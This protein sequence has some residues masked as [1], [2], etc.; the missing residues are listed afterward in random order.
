MYDFTGFSDMQ[1][2]MVM[3]YINAVAFDAAEYLV[4]QES[5]SDLLN[6]KKLLCE[7]IDLAFLDPNVANYLISTSVETFFKQA[8]RTSYQ[9]IDP[10]LEYKELYICFPRVVQKSSKL[11]MSFHEGLQKLNHPGVLDKILPINV[12]SNTRYSAG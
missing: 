9:F 12:F 5:G 11:S 4:I 10:G 6:L 8:T 3:G 7:R 2:G 1:I